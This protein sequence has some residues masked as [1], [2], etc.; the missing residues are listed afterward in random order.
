[1]DDP[2]G[3]AGKTV[4][5][6]GAASGM[7][8]AAAQILADLGADVIGLDIKPVTVVGA[9]SV[10]ID[11]KD[12]ASIDEV[13]A[14]ITGPLQAVVS[15]AGLPGPPFSLTDTMVVN[16]VGGRHLI[17][18]LVPK[19]APDGAICCVSS[20]AG[21]GWQQEMET[22]MPLITSDGF[23]AGK[24][25][26]EANQETVG[27]GMANAYGFSKKALSSWCA[28]RAASMITQGIRLNNINPGPTQTPMMPQ[29]IEAAS[30]ELIENFLGPIAR[31]STPEEQAWPLVMLCSPRMSF[32]NGVGLATD[33]G[34]EG[35]LFTGQIDFSALIP[36]E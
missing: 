27:M 34:F 2:L 16:F 15:C 35:A 8:G 29:F 1:M 33:G 11:L 19:M 4:V 24:A 10:I 7:G 9:Q 5:V 17:E 28:W 30:Q 6:T 36:T 32:V 18:S 20:N 12:K 23:E 25:W 26:V 22:L 21:L 14:G 31:Y 3:Y 13:V